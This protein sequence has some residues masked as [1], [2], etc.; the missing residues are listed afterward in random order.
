MQQNAVIVEENRM[1]LKVAKKR[2]IQNSDMAQNPLRDFYFLCFT[3]LLIFG[4]TLTLPLNANLS[5]L[6]FMAFWLAGMIS[7]KDR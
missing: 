6:E 3:G 5:L 4:L 1:D 7:D 2:Q